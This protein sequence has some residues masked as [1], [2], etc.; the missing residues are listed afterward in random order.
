MKQSVREYQRNLLQISL[1]PK[2]NISPSY[3]LPLSSVKNL[4]STQITKPARRLSGNTFDP[5]FFVDNYGPQKEIKLPNQNEPG[6]DFSLKNTLL[7][8]QKKT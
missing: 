7:L 1:K 8:V 2:N 4:R 5:Q 6:Q 3:K